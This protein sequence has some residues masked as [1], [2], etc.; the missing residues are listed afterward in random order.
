[1]GIRHPT[2]QKFRRGDL[3][4]ITKDMPHWMRH[5][6]SDKDAI[7]LY[8]YA[9][10]YGSESIERNHKQYSVLF[11]P[12]GDECSWYDEDQLTFI[13]HVGEVGIEQV[14]L[15]RSQRESN[16]KNL[17]WIVANWPTIRDNVPGATMSE[18]LRLAGVKYPWGPH[19]E[20]YI[21]YQY[22]RYLFKH[23]DP[24]LSTGDKSAVEQK[25]AELERRVALG[26][27]R[28]DGG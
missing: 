15:L 14:S 22:A 2:L 28:G 9:E 19:G 16:E 4:H 10:R 18:L 24:V 6:D 23:I 26:R 25:L 12:D 3:V 1:M 5:F 11:W 21:Y 8:S 17:D 13:R 20:G 7:V 27:G